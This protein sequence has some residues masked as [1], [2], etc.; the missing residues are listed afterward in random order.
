MTGKQL[1]DMQTIIEKIRRLSQYMME[2]GLPNYS[3]TLQQYCK[4]L[5]EVIW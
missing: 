5:E 2:E 4:E 3:L 1:I